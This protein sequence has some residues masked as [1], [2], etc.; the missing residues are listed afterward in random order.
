MQELVDRVDIEEL[1][2]TLTHLASFRT[3]HSTSTQFSTALG[4]AD[5]QLSALGYVTRREAITVR[6]KPSQN[7]VA[8]MAGVG[9]EPRRL[10]VVVAHLDSVNVAGADAP[11]LG[12]R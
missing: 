7:L 6:G 2:T 10:V 3:R 11:A 1:R 9:A 12:C 5:D 4:W 8:D